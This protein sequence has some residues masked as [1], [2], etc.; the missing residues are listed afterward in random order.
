MLLVFWWMK[1]ENRDLAIDLATESLQGRIS[2][3]EKVVLKVN[4]SVYIAGHTY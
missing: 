2:V 3:T 1:I 4:N